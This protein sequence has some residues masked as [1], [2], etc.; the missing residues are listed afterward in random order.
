LIATGGDN[1]ADLAIMRTADHDYKPVHTLIGHRDWVFGAAW[2][3]DRHVVTGSRDQS[4]SLWQVDPDDVALGDAPTVL[5][6]DYYSKSMKRKFEGKVREVKY[7]SSRG[8]V[9]ALST[10]C[11]VQLM[12]PGRDLRTLRS[13]SC[14][15]NVTVQFWPFERGRVV[16]ICSH[17][18]Q[19]QL[20]TCTA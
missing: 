6:H 18:V 14:K 7:D 11:A 3:T 12:D 20:P 1:P 2:V 16:E 17:R 15:T 19:S 13:V 4:V 5:N 9:A 8:Y 10:S